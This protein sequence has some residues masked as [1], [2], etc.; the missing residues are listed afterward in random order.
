MDGPAMESSSG[1]MSMSPSS[2]MSGMSMSSPT[3]SMSMSSDPS[4]MS[5]A[6]MTMTF[7][8]SATTPL[9]SMDWTPHTTGQYA[10]TCIFLIAFASLFRAL[11]AIRVHFWPLLAE[12]DKRRFGGVDYD[13]FRASPST[14]RP[15]R[16]RDAVWVASL[17]VIIAGAGYLLYGPCLHYTEGS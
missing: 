2:T 12:Y 13:S 15:W 17:D 4:T 10:G 6:D 16:A 5:M 8:T 1:T 14:T 9:Y 7:F 11:V 3:S